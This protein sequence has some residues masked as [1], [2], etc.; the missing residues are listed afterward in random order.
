MLSAYSSSAG[1]CG[2]AQLRAAA[3]AADLIVYEEALTPGWQNV[4]QVP[5]YAALTRADVLDP[6]SKDIKDRVQALAEIW[7]GLPA[8]VLERRKLPKH[9]KPIRRGTVRE[10]GPK[11]PEDAEEA[12]LL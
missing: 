8:E 2:A 3:T 6:K 7:P 1:Y 11:E 12:G 4:L 10:A 9:A 5:A